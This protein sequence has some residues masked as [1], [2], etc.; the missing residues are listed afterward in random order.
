MAICLQSGRISLAMLL[1]ANLIQMAIIQK[2]TAVLTENEILLFNPNGSLRFNHGLPDCPEQFS[3]TG[4]NLVIE[5]MEGDSFSL[6]VETGQFRKLVGE[7][8]SS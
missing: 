2:V 3:I 5:L 1:T 7:V 8:L 4:N 6:N